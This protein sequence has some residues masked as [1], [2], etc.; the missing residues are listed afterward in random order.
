M[1]NVKTYLATRSA[2]FSRVDAPLYSSQRLSSTTRSELDSLPFGAAPGIASARRPCPC[3]LR[4]LFYLEPITPRPERNL[5]P[6]T[7]Y[8]SLLYSAWLMIFII[9]NT[10]SNTA[11]AGYIR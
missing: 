7:H 9:R 10:T 4:I 8:A 6:S 3:I 5:F 11:L 1:L 2:F